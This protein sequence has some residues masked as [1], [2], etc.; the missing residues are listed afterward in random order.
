MTSYTMHVSLEFYCKL[1]VLV[2][3]SNFKSVIFQNYLLH[4]LKLQI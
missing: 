3:I 4:F 2:M 1:K